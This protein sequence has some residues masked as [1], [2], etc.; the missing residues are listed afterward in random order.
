[1]GTRVGEFEI[2]CRDRSLV[3]IRKGQVRRREG[4]IRT[5]N[6][7]PRKMKRRESKK[8]VSNKGE[9]NIYHI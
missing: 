5:K 6:E 2:I 4:K 1:M 9:Q 7:V 3:Y 8:I